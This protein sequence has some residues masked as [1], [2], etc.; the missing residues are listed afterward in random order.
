MDWLRS[1]DTL[2]EKNLNWIEFEPAKSTVLLISKSGN[3]ELSAQEYTVQSE[4]DW[5]AWLDQASLTFNRHTHQP[6]VKTGT[7]LRLILGARADSGGPDPGV[8]SYLPFSKS[9]FRRLIS[10]FKIHGTIARTISRNTSCAFIRKFRSGSSP[11]EQSIVYNCRSSASWDGDLSLS[12]TFT[13]RTLTSH[14][15][16]YGCNAEITE[17]ITNRLPTSD[18]SS[19]HPM[20]LVVLFAELERNRLD[21]LVRDKFTQLFQQIVNISTKRDVSTIE[22]QDSSSQS[23]SPA[24]S[25]LDCLNMGGLRNEL[26]T[27]KRKIEANFAASLDADTL[28]GLH[29]TGVIMKERLKH[30]VDE[31]DELIGK[32]TTMIEGVGLKSQL[33]ITSIFL[34][35][36]ASSHL[37]VETSILTRDAFSQE[38]NQIG[39]KDTMINLAISQNELET[40]KLLA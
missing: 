6:E 25:I 32:C 27:F 28:S 24:I 2:W 4:K 11:D 34:F 7:K 31:F 13:L 10:T 38:S 18:V 22:N 16:I 39:R 23:P 33:V 37:I 29:E 12:V 14:A 19:L 9:T 30:L 21:R 20:L 15:V 26:Q 1:D 17:E 3:A 8:L 40:A 36:F 35:H 5:E